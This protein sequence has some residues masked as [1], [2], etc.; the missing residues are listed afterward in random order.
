MLGVLKQWSLFVGHRELY[1]GEWRLHN[2]Q[3]REKPA[4]HSSEGHDGVVL[5]W[6]NAQ[7]SLSFVCGQARD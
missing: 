6:G 7:I 5:S 1:E 2:N 3:Q 4:G